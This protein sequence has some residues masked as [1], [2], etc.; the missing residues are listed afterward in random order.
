[1]R[2]F[3]GGRSVQVHQVQAGPSLCLP[4]PGHGQGIDGEYGL[5]PEVAL[6]QPHASAAAKVNCRD[7][8]HIRQPGKR[9][10]N[11]AK[12]PPS[13]GEGGVGVRVS[14]TSVSPMR[15]TCLCHLHEVPIDAEADGPALLRVEL[16]GDHII[17]GVGAAER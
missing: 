11:Y 14:A 9:S 17:P 8:F 2:G 3:A 5:P 6:A 10:A 16:G 4:A 1:M 7:Y 13:Q 15:Y 12:L